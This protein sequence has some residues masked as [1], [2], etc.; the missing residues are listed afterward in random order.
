LGV[1]AGRWYQRS[2]I[3][4]R[5]APDRAAI[6]SASFAAAANL[7]VVVTAVI[8]LSIVQDTLFGGIPALFKLWL[9]VPLI[10][11]AA[12]LYLLYRSVLVWRHGLLAGTWARVRLTVVT[13]CAL[14][15]C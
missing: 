14:F 12:G 13:L 7:L 9:V 8:V 15:M 4:S 1:L 10:A 2:L 3:R 6:N 5:A 11:V